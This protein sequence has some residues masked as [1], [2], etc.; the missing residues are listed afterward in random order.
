MDMP[1]GQHMKPPFRSRLTLLARR[2]ADMA[3]AHE[4]SARIGTKR[5]GFRPAWAVLS[6]AG[7]YGDIA[8]KVARRGD[9]AWDHRVTTSKAEKAGFILR[10]FAQANARMAL[11]DTPRAPG[12]WTRPRQGA[13]PAGPCKG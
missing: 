10:A 1:P 2:L 13:L 11:P 9:H 3:A 5:L 4:E 12:L 6:A 8:R 7:I